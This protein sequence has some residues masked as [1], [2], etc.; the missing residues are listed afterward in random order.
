MRLTPLSILL[1]ALVI[2]A[3]VF[4]LAFPFGGMIGGS[5][6]RCPYCGA[7][8]ACYNAAI[9]S[10]L[11]PPRGGEYVWT[12]STRTYQF[13]APRAVG[14]WLLGLASTPYYCVVSISPVLVCSG[15]HID[16]M[17][18]SAV[19]G[20]DRNLQFCDYKWKYA[21][22]KSG[23][24]YDAAEGK[25]RELATAMTQESKPEDSAR[26]TQTADEMKAERQ[27]RYGSQ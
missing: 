15:S 4:A 26:Y 16:M 21:C 12:P 19:G 20:A 25:L 9:Y 23:A 22:Y 8:C 24:E 11:G 27:A 14:Q 7:V 18:S 5:G 1:V 2:V 13:G 17:G 3:P 6:P 10:N